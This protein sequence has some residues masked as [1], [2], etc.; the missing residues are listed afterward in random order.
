MKKWSY[1]LGQHL[2]KC[3]EINSKINVRM[4]FW[5]WWGVVGAYLTPPPFTLNYT[6]VIML[7]DYDV[8]KW[9][10]EDR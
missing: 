5:K 1:I 7:Q 2:K 6:L 8:G 4:R 3:N 10:E 9:A